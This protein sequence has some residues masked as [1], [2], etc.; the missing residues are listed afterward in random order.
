MTYQID[1]ELEPEYKLTK[2]F[3]A[4]YH[5]DDTLWSVHVDPQAGTMRPLVSEAPA[6]AAGARVALQYGTKVVGHAVVRDS[7]VP[8][9]SAVPDPIAT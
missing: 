4:M 5:Q 7:P 6:I 2:P 1:L 9:A 8:G 3:W